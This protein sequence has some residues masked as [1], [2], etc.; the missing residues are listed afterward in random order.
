MIQFF[1][2]IFNLIATILSFIVHALQS[3]ITF[4]A[5]IPSYVNFLTTIVGS[6]PPFLI[7]FVTISITL[8]VLTIFINREVGDNWYM[9]NVCNYFTRLV[10]QGLVS[11]FGV[12]VDG[13]TFNL[14]QIIVVVFIFRLFLIS[15]LRSAAAPANSYN[16][17]V[18]KSQ[19]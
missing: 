19:N 6:L 14:G 7:P 4:I 12:Y 17:A 16:N 18:K 3:F 10:F 11:F 1:E 15:I 8:S 13:L 5:S 9:W 2:S